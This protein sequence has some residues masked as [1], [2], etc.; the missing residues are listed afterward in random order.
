MLVPGLWAS[1]ASDL[2]LALMNEELATEEE[3]DAEEL[4]ERESPSSTRCVGRCSKALADVA[5]VIEAVFAASEE[6]RGGPKE[7]LRPAPR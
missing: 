2:S 1:G 7:A 6:G 3:G 4:G 5:L